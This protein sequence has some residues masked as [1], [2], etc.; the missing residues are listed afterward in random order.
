[1][2]HLEGMP[3]GSNIWAHGYQAYFPSR[4]GAFFFF[5]KGVIKDIEMMIIDN[6]V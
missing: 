6:Y 1:M 2:P 4:F 5:W 3:C